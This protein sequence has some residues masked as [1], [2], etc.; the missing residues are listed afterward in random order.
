MKKWYAYWPAKV[1][2]GIIGFIILF[3]MNPK[4][5]ICQGFTVLKNHLKAKK[6]NN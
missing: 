3:V 5:F 2:G 1:I 6:S 4:E